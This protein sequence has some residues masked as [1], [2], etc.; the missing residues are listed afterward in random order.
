MDRCFL[1]GCAGAVDAD[2]PGIEL[3][4]AAVLALVALRQ[5]T[6]TT[7]AHLAVEEFPVGVGGVAQA[8][9]V[10]LRAV[11]EF[12]GEASGQTLSHDLL[13][14]GR[15][16]VLHGPGTIR[17]RPARVEH[18]GDPAGEVEGVLGLEKT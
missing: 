13:P 8:V 7:A 11:G 10:F 5:P 18:I 14:L 6:G 2:V 4:T 3:H 9:A 12:T 17:R 15:S 1:G 16:P